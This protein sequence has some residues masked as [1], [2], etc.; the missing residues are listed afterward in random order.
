MSVNL[1][2]YP[3]LNPFPSRAKRSFPIASFIIN[4][5]PCTA[6]PYPSIFSSNNNGEID[7]SSLYAYGIENGYGFAVK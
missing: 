6:T 1:Q 2:Y 4:Q 7:E 5:L 3:Y